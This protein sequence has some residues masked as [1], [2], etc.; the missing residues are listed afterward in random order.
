[1]LNLLS[2][3]Q[4]TYKSRPCV[5]QEEEVH[6]SYTVTYFPQLTPLTVHR[7]LHFT[8]SKMFNKALL[9]L[10]LSITALTL[11]NTKESLEKRDSKGWIGSFDGADTDCSGDIVSHRPKFGIGGCIS[12]DATTPNIGTWNPQPA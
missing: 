10:A 5:F 12:F 8:S 2:G 3:F 1:M 9:F 6:A 11:P 4:Q 7:Q